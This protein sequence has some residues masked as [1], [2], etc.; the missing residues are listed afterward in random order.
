MYQFD[1]HKKFKILFIHSENFLSPAWS[2]IKSPQYPTLK[3]H[4]YFK[5]V[6]ISINN[7]ILEIIK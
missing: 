4:T 2:F 1:C 3:L 7:I 6:I 5:Y